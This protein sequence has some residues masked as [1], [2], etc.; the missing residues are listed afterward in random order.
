MISE[1]RE[2]KSEWKEEMREKN[3]DATKTPTGMCSKPRTVG[4]EG[5]CSVARNA[6]FRKTT[7]LKGKGKE[8]D[9]HRK[10][11]ENSH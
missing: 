9:N 1:K 5:S 7:G 2:K 6:K 4:E 10:K 11:T 8:L 3:N